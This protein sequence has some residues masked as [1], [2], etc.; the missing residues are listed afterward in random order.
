[1]T[2]EQL[3]KLNAEGLASGIPIGELNAR[4]SKLSRIKGGGVARLLGDR[5]ARGV[6]HFRCSQ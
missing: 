4:R 3:G 6:I 2:F 5:P 1:M